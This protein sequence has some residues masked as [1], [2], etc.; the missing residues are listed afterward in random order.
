MV[1]ILLFTCGCKENEL[2]SVPMF[3]ARFNRISDSRIDRKNICAVEN[4]DTLVYSFLPDGVFLLT[5]RAQKNSGR[6]KQCSVTSEK[7]KELRE[8][9]FFQKC[10][11][12]IASYEKCDVSHAE[13]ILAS[14]SF[15]KGD[16]SARDGFFRIYFSVN[17][18]AVHFSIES[19]RLNEERTTDKKLYE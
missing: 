11:E 14:F 1:F 13:D 5:L 17:E 12:V 6:I 4:G 3:I 15:K 10:A 16:S 19:S 9:D 18:V 2:I 7:T 8:S